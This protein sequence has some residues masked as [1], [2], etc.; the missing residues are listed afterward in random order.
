[1]NYKRHLFFEELRGKIDELYRAKEEH[2]RKKKFYTYT[3]SSY[4]E[5]Y[6]NCLFDCKEITDYQWYKLLDVIREKINFRLKRPIKMS[7][8]LYKRPTVLEFVEALEREA[9]LYRENKTGELDILDCLDRIEEIVD[10]LRTRLKKIG[11]R[12]W[13]RWCKRTQENNERL[14]R[15]REASKKESK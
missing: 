14:R 10:D 9:K 4:M 1:M 6:L 2:Y 8:T 15:L 7:E 11:N 3:N 5:G 13:V 12:N